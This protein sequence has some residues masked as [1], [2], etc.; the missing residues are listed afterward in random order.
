MLASI[1][2]PCLFPTFLVPKTKSDHIHECIF[3]HWL[4]VGGKR[5]SCKARFLQHQLWGQ[6]TWAIFMVLLK[7]QSQKQDIMKNAIQL[8]F[9]LDY[10]FIF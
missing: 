1:P 7:H 9:T 5:L 4:K 8:L 10:N 6:H 2:P 3:F